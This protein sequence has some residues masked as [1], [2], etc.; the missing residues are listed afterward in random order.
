M[1]RARRLLRWIRTVPLAVRL[2]LLNTLAMAALFA[3]LQSGLNLSAL[4]GVG[5]AALEPQ[6]SA[7]VAAPLFGLVGAGT[8]AI[9]LRLTSPQYRR[10]RVWRML[11]LVA[12]WVG[13]CSTLTLPMQASICWLTPAA[14]LTTVLLMQ[15][16]G[17][18]FL[19][20]SGGLTGVLVLSLASIVGGLNPPWL[21]L[22]G[23]LVG[24]FSGTILVSGLDDDRER[25][26]A[27]HDRLAEARSVPPG[28]LTIGA[29]GEIVV[30]TDAD[31]AQRARGAGCGDAQHVL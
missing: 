25:L 24:F 9:T 14:L 18:A 15:R 1:K 20:M 21:P 6:P 11:L 26:E 10:F 29:D 27:Q 31:D 8:L 12:L 4:F 30:V 28:R 19:L 7:G 3:L 17:Q 5:V 2:I 13:V 22:T 23:A 16:A